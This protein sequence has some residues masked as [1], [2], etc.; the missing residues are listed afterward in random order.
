MHLISEDL[1]SHHH[2]QLHLPS[3]VQHPVTSLP[4]RDPDGGYISLV[5]G[6]TRMSLPSHTFIRNG[7]VNIAI[8]II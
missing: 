1:S 8:A 6:Q 3:D 5:I 2:T 4:S 7:H